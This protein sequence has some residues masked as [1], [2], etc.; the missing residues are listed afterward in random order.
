MAS[1]A[2]MA[3]IGR[4]IGAYKAR[5]KPWMSFFSA[6][7]AGAFIALAFVFYTTT[8]TGVS[9]NASWGMTKLVG[10][11]VF[12]LG[13]ILVVIC[14][15]ELFTSST[16]TMLAK[17]TGQI[18]TTQ[19]L[20]NW[21]IVYLGN[22]V[23]ALFIVML[24]WFSGQIMACNGQWGL[25][26]LKT[27]SHKIHHSFIEA[28]CLGILCNMMVCGAVWLSYAGKSVTDKILVML[29][30]VAMFVASGFEHS[31]ANMFMIPM[32]III[33]NFADSHFWMI[34]T[35][36]DII[37]NNLDMYHFIVK[38]LIPVTLGNIVGG[39][40]CIA[41]VQYYLNKVNH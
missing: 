7:T 21:F 5:K 31:I 19:M 30:P 29:L 17:V 38:N 26:I 23:G 14:G 28:F 16:M 39:G 34:T 33:K 4:D 25:T 11:I 40:I 8:Q 15:A 22:F 2:K 36:P 37:F 27:A 20:R 12:A 18:S 1:P 6:I 13:L 32:G 10:G 41:L 3:E 24:I 35:T 9:A